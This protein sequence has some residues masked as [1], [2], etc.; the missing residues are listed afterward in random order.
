[1]ERN[2]NKSY[3]L[4]LAALFLAVGMILPFFTAQIP[5]IGSMLLPM[6][7]PVLICGFV[8]GWR[9]GLIVGFITPLLR[10]M[11]FS[12]P[13]LFPSATAMAFEMA[14]Y[15][16]ICGLLYA[17]LPRGTKSVYVS[18]LAAMAGGRIVWGLVEIPILGIAGRGYSWQAFVA[19]AFLNAVPGIILQIVMVPLIVIALERANVMEMQE[20]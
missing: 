20:K 10:S 14:A 1:M 9:Y 19:G 18:L 17:R 3:K 12:M 2:R 11:T 6:H 15:G 13:P 4:V 16:A 7:I 5:E 8:C